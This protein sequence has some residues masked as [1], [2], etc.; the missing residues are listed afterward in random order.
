MDSHES[1]A[2]VT[3]R[4]PSQRLRRY[5]IA[6]VLV[7]TP[8]VVTIFILQFLVGLMDRSLVLLPEAWR[9][10]NL[11]GFAVPGLGLVLAVVV[12]AITGLLATNLV[13]RRLM[14]WGDRLVRRIPI[15]RSIYSGAKTFTE[16]VFSSKGQAFKQVL[17]VQYPRQGVWS[18]GFQSGEDIAEATHRT[19]R[20]LVVV[21]MPTT[22]N[23][24]SGF[25]VMV[26][27]E[28]VIPLEMTIDEAMRLILTLGVVAPPW[29]GNRPVQT[30][31]P[32]LQDPPPKA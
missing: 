14:S 10:E 28:E 25:I 32:G 27:R 2:D 4:S 26:P 15:V 19:G 20:D 23:P 31:L 30:E 18:I 21:F 3:E 6:G 17:L 9:P 7:W 29:P 8:I 1:L 12:L 16:T 24:T 22:P 5:L 11:F 13:G